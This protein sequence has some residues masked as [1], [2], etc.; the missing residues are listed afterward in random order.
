MT[1]AL[2]IGGQEVRAFRA[3]TTEMPFGIALAWA[4]VDLHLSFWF[5]VAR[6]VLETP[7]D[8]CE[9][10]KQNDESYVSDDVVRRRAGLVRT[11]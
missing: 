3:A 11:W 8:W 10:L 6:L 9:A 1:E 7:W 2:W 4:V 5:R